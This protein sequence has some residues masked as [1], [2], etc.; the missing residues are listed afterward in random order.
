MEVGVAL[1][2]FVPGS[3]VCIFIYANVLY[4]TTYYIAIRPTP[5]TIKYTIYNQ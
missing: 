2:H 5:P 1:M 4:Y 3:H